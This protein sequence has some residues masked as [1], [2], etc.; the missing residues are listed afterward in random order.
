MDTMLLKKKG[1]LQANKLM[2]IDFNYITNLKANTYSIGLKDLVT[3]Y[4]SWWH[5]ARKLQDHGENF[6]VDFHPYNNLSNDE[7]ADLKTIKAINWSKNL[8]ES[9][10]NQTETLQALNSTFIK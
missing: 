8:R 5:L 2:T 3:W 9:E 4:S 10:L 1:Q 7:H 6:S